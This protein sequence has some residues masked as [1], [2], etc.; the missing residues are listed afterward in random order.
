LTIGQ[1]GR[2]EGLGFKVLSLDQVESIP[3]ADEFEEAIYPPPSGKLYAAKVEIK[4]FG[5]VK[6]DRSAAV[7]VGPSCWTST[8]ATT[9]TKTR[10][11]LPETTGFASTESRQGSPRRPHSASRC[12]ARSGGAGWSYGTPA[13]PTSTGR[14]ATSS[15]SLETAPADDWVRGK[16][17]LPRV[18]R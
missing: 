5:D 9:S 13:R 2:D 8:T 7:P 12:R 10:W 4:N 11:A 3:P 17:S 14:K 18:A 6:A 15:S 1:G 16:T